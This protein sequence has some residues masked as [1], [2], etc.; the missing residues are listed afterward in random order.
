MQFIPYYS[1][2]VFVILLLIILYSPLFISK[3]YSNKYEKPI[4]SIDM[5]N[6]K[7]P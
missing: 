3:L 6:G 7:A 2:G 1:F 4:D 5:S